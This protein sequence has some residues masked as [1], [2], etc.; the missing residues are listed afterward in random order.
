MIAYIIDSLFFAD[1]LDSQ[2]CYSVLAAFADETGVH[3]I[4]E[5]KADASLAD[6]IE[7]L[8]I[9]AGYKYTFDV[10]NNPEGKEVPAIFAE[11]LVNECDATS[12]GEY[13]DLEIR[14]IQRID[15]N[16]INGLKTL[17]ANPETKDA[18]LTFFCNYT[19]ISFQLCHATKNE[20]IYLKELP[21][22][23][24]FAIVVGQRVHSSLKT[25]SDFWEDG[26]LK[27]ILSGKNI[28][29]FAHMKSRATSF[30][31]EPVISLADVKAHPEYFHFIR[32]E[33]RDGKTILGSYSYF[34]T[35]NIV[36]STDISSV[37]K[38]SSFVDPKKISPVSD[39]E[40]VHAC[41]ACFADKLLITSEQSGMQFVVGL[42]HNGKCITMKDIVHLKGTYNLLRSILADG[43]K[44]ATA[45]FGSNEGKPTCKIMYIPN[46][47]VEQKI[48]NGTLVV[49]DVTRLPASE[50]R[51]ELLSAFTEVANKGIHTVNLTELEAANS[52]LPENQGASGSASAALEA[53]SNSFDDTLDTVE[54]FTLCDCIEESVGFNSQSAAYK[55]ASDVLNSINRTV[56]QNTCV[57]TFNRQLPSFTDLLWIFDE[58]YQAA[59]KATAQTVSA[60]STNRTNVF[61]DDASETAI[62]EDIDDSVENDESDDNIDI[63]DVDDMEDKSLSY[64]DLDYLHID[65][66]YMR[67][68]A[69]TEAHNGSMGLGPYFDSKYYREIYAAFGPSVIASPE[70]IEGNNAN[71]KLAIQ[72]NEILLFAGLYK[73]VLEGLCYENKFYTLAEVKKALSDGMHSVIADKFIRLLTQDVFNLNWRH[74]G[75]VKATLSRMTDKRDI[76]FYNATAEHASSET[77]MCLGWYNV[78]VNNGKPTVVFKDGNDDE[79]FPSVAGYIS[80]EIINSMSWVE[81]FIRLARW[82]T[83][84]PRQL[85]IPSKKLN[86]NMETFLNLVSFTKQDWCGTFDEAKRVLL[87]G[88]PFTID[89]RLSC[90][91]SKASGLIQALTYFNEKL[92]SDAEIVY[93]VP[94]CTRYEDTE[95]T[96]VFYIDIFTLVSSIADNKLSV[97]GIMFDKETQNFESSIVSSDTLIMDPN[98]YYNNDSFVVPLTTA[99]NNSKSQPAAFETMISIHLTRLWTLTNLAQCLGSKFPST[100]ILDMLRFFEMTTV[101]SNLL[102]RCSKVLETSPNLRENLIKNLNRDYGNSITAESLANMIMFTNLALPY[103]KLAQEIQEFKK[104]TGNKPEIA[105]VLNMARAVDLNRAATKSSAE[106]TTATPQS[107]LFKNYYNKCTQFYSFALEGRTMLYIGVINTV[108]QGK[109]QSSYVL[110]EPDDIPNMVA[111]GCEDKTALAEPATFEFVTNSVVLPYWSHCKIAYAGKNK[112]EI[113]DVARRN[114]LTTL[115]NLRQS[116]YIS[117]RN[118]VTGSTQAVCDTFTKF[119]F[120]VWVAE[121]R[122]QNRR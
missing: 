89:G 50:M 85:W 52:C 33:D 112:T 38:L 115:K 73:L 10:L 60:D 96:R 15:N 65:L 93:G 9:F 7:K 103:I 23:K 37:E 34:S 119:V 66:E 101:D 19:D 104:K 41:N 51:T 68:D 20:V 63:D 57:S 108:I 98:E 4:S 47:A 69:N 120:D 117:F 24:D 21:D 109:Q 102:D 12:L 1:N 55:Q 92:D 72:S 75:T 59:I 118:G 35:C 25:I 70:C 5:I 114:A 42:I 80:S 11:I 54:Q 49:E 84:K 32:D 87:D 6:K 99:I 77:F 76:E 31:V 53:L 106:T 36:S 30:S 86:R 110:W 88:A 83:R 40:A 8:P 43:N 2:N 81:A 13:P 29:L 90:E 28:E 113:T 14:R 64:A 22:S 45:I 56:V 74:T 46:A 100:R 67:L 16:I 111:I 61:D 107:A 44:F 48:E 62:V 58:D 39:E 94:L 18:G 27:S 3:S 78:I 71:N 82:N 79:R 105:D 95:E 122:K 97:A 116:R 26:T 121:V 91:A 17:I